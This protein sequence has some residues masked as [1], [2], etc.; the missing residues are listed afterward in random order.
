MIAYFTIFYC[1][2]TNDN[3]AYR[4]I[5]MFV[6]MI[7]VSQMMN[8]FPNFFLAM[9]QFFTSDPVVIAFTLLQL[10]FLIAQVVVGVMLY[11]RAQGYRMM[12][13]DDFRKVRLFAIL[14]ASM[15]GLSLL[16][17]IVA[18]SVGV[19]FSTPLDATFFYVT[20]FS[21]PLSEVL[22]AVSVVFT[23]ERLRRD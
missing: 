23:F 4:G 17:S 5:V 11:L 9:D 22:M 21:L 3:A 8:L 10:A 13:Y 6:F 20:L 18:T 1:N 12:R 15:L 16:S 2:V 7:V 19:K 14:F